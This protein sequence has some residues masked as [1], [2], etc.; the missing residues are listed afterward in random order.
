MDSYG[1]IIENIEHNLYSLAPLLTPLKIAI[2]A[3]K[4]VNLEHVKNTGVK[5]NSSTTVGTPNKWTPNK[6]IYAL[7][8]PILPI[9]YVSLFGLTTV[10]ELLTIRT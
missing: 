9:F 10:A 2:L 8:D 7:F 4:G 6:A 3:E 1:L 5:L